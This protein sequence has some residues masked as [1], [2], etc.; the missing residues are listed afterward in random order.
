MRPPRLPQVISLQP[1]GY[2]AKDITVLLKVQEN[3]GAQTRFLLDNASLRYT[4]FGL[5]LNN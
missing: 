5:Q 1:S 4:H 2:S 3:D